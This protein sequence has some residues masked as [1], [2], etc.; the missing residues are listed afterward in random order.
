MNLDP[1]LKLRPG[2]HRFTNRSLHRKLL[3]SGKLDLQYLAAKHCFYNLELQ[4][5]IEVAASL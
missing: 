1:S 3:H 2:S 5:L 4:E